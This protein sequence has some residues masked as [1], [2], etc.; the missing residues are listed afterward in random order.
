MYQWCHKV[1][2]RDRDVAKI[3][4]LTSAEIRALGQTS[5]KGGLALDHRVTPYAFWFV[6]LPPVQMSLTRP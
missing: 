4:L 1:F 5:E 6:E 2:S 3:H